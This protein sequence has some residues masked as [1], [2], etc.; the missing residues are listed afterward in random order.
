[1]SR[2][3]Q[4]KAECRESRAVPFN[5]NALV[6]ACAADG[7]LTSADVDVMGRLDSPTK[8]EPL[9]F[10]RQL[11]PGTMAGR[12]PLAPVQGNARVGEVDVV[13]DALGMEL[14]ALE[15]QV[16]SLQLRVKAQDK[17]LRSFCQLEVA[18]KRA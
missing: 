10:Q 12:A 16:H 2:S 17:V 13:R 5:A 14:R 18:R 4:S 3:R 1:M 8:H 15:A 6:W 9:P 7:V 11:R